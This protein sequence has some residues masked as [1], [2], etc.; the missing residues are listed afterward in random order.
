MKL[1]YGRAIVA[2]VA[3][4]ILVLGGSFAFFT[5][6]AGTS[7]RLSPSTGAL[8]HLTPFGTVAKTSTVVA[9]YAV[10]TGRGAVSDVRAQWHVPQIAAACSSGNSYS[11]FEVGIDGY[12]SPSLELLGT[13]TSCSGGS[14]HYSAFWEVYPKTGGSIGLTLSPADHVSAEISYHAG[15]FTFHLKDLTTGK[16]FSKSVLYAAAYRNSAQWLVSAAY[17][18]T[19]I[20]PL[21]DFGWVVFT[22]TNATVSGHTHPVGGFSNVKLTMISQTGAKVMAS[23][24]GGLTSGG[25]VFRVNWHYR[26]P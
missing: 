22:N 9:G 5:A 17:S 12:S 7:A 25:S 13:E 4:S 19:T 15:S 18:T 1:R 24:S 3:L 26:G 8:S 20:Y 10:T 6:N 21:T 2:G 23:V 14:A 11:F 16:S